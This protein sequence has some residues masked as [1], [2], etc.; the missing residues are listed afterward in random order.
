[1]KPRR[2]RIGASAPGKGHDEGQKRPAGQGSRPR[3]ALGL[4]GGLLV[5]TGAAYLGAA[6]VLHAVVDTDELARWLEPKAGAA[7]NR[8]VTVEGAS[9]SVFPLPALN[10]EGVEVG[11]LPGFDGPPLAH[12]RRLRLKVALLPLLTGTVRV[13]RVALQDPVLHLAVDAEGRSNYGDL[14]PASQDVPENA[15]EAPFEVEVREV[16]VSG[17]RVTVL[18][19]PSRE[20]LVLF[21]LA[22]KTRVRPQREGGWNLAASVRTDSLLLRRPSLGDRTY[23]ATQSSVRLEAASDSAL[24]RL[25]VNRGEVAVAG[26]KVNVS[27]QIDSLRSARRWVDIHLA[28]DTIPLGDVV[29]A[30]SDTLR[31]RL[32]SEA[33]GN[34]ALDLTLRGA[35]DGDQRPRLQGKV[36][37]DRVGLG[38]GAVS[39]VQDLSGE[40]VMEEGGADSASFRGTLLGGP[41]VVEVPAGGGEAPKRLRVEAHPVLGQLQ[42]LGMMAPGA[43]FSGNADVDVTVTGALGA[44]EEMRLEGHLTASG[45]RAELPELGESV[46]VPR[47][48]LRL[49]GNEGQWA[50]VTVLLG[51]DPLSTTGRITGLSSLLAGSRDEL[52]VVRAEV[53]APRLRLDR[54][55][56]PGGGA[57]GPTYARIAFARLGGRSPGGVSPDEMARARGLTRPRSLPLE[58]VVDVRLDTLHYGLHHLEHVTGRVEL[59]R[60]SLAVTGVQMRA[61]GGTVSGA[62]TLALGPDLQEPFTLVLEAS[63]V[64]GPAFMSSLTPFGEL[65]Q[66]RLYVALDL[67][68]ATDTLL[69]PAPGA[70]TGDGRV[71]VHGGSLEANPVTGSLSGFLEREAWGSPAFRSWFATFDVGDGAFD[72]RESELDSP[73]GRLRATGAI[74]LDGQVDLELG[75]SIP[76]EELASVSLRRT[77]IAASV[78]SRL[79][80]AGSPVQLGLHLRGSLDRPV[81][82]PDGGVAAVEVTARRE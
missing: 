57:E 28:A 56:P 61:W 34:I 58:G 10:A 39:L 12:V 20:S 19:E 49:Q 8:H 2:V 24:Q 40:L 43:G 80:Q 41:F 75:V 47:V 25:W 15:P 77:G 42:Q 70:L 64:Q 71:V 33:R 73:L 69:L 76:A 14:V 16:T 63:G 35:V 74:G 45:I 54:I 81:L 6:A 65:V 67:S 23:R 32:P 13:G 59:G 52:P 4:L 62:L 11:N 36:T 82:E 3:W 7:L 51:E 72:L 48:D 46:Y 50:D 44:P 31:S 37:L 66:G 1:M 60:E 21:G 26:A 38:E 79:V 5:A 30:L 29:A 55:L 27:G 9:L 17:A 53:R 78:V 18:R 22:G 68:G